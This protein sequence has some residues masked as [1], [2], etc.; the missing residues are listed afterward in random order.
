MA[1]GERPAVAS[2]PR[3]DTR[4]G[5]KSPV[6]RCREGRPRLAA[7][8]QAMAN[9]LAAA[10][11]FSLRVSGL[12]FEGGNRVSDDT[13]IFVGA[14]TVREKQALHDPQVFRSRD[15]S[16]GASPKPEGQWHEQ[17]ELS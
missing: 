1:L 2:S 17:D 5:L 14:N 6:D 4:A 12:D 16:D 7:Y 13:R 11:Y 10:N 8:D 9:A 15:R 3:R